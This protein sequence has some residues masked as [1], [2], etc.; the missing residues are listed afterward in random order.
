M[1]NVI[2]LPRVWQTSEVSQLQLKN[3][4]QL[5]RVRSG[6]LV[7]DGLVTVRSGLFNWLQ[8]KR[9]EH[10]SLFTPHSLHLVS[11]LQRLIVEDPRGKSTK[12]SLD[13]WVIL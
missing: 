1:H 4:L 6:Q 12:G 5:K 3:S 11:L 8:L 10:S 7:T 2:F 9:A 13:C